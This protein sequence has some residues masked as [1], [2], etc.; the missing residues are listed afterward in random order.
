[1]SYGLPGDEDPILASENHCRKC[2]DI[3][4]RDL[5]G[6]SYCPTCDREEVKEEGE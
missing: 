3:L 6:D 4:D 1:M 2:D 5:L